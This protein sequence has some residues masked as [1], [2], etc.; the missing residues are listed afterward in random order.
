MTDLIS[1]QDAIEVADAVWCVTG[2]KQVAKVWQQ[3]QDLPTIEERKTGRW[4][5]VIGDGSLY[6][7][8]QCHERSCCRGRFCMDCGAR[9]VEHD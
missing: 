4:I 6:E 9:M 5:D 3:I 7:C 2:D 8:D 1:R